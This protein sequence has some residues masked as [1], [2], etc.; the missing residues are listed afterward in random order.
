MK[1]DTC[2]I[3]QRPLA[4]RIE[5]GGRLGGGRRCIGNLGV[6]RELRVL[7]KQINLFAPDYHTL[8][9]L[10]RLLSSDKLS[11]FIKFWRKKF[12]IRDFSKFFKHYASRTV[13]IINVVRAGTKRSATTRVSVTCSGK[14][15]H[16]VR[17]QINL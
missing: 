9:N 3:M 13:K 17:R 7:Y 5:F 10:L 12:N 6:L 2:F 11:N 8:L 16:S 15:Q 1:H 4:P 14:Q